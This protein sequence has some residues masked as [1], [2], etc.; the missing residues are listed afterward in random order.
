MANS[1][2]FTINIDDNGSLQMVAKDSKKAA[3]GIQDVD[4]AT[5]KANKSRGKYQKQEKG[6]GQAGL[7]SAKSFSKMSSGISGGLVPAYAVLAAN[8]FAVTA[9]FGALSRAA[10]V[11]QL[12]QGLTVLGTAS[13]IAMKT[14]ILRS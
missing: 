7:S 1:I 11:E 14:S 8:V 13:G 3:K 5:S 2:K 4:N 9:A 12:T 10:K 6:I